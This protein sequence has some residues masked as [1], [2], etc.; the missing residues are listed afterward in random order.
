MFQQQNYFE[1]DD[2]I[3]HEPKEIDRRIRPPGM[4]V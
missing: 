3:G 4:T 1:D 2:M